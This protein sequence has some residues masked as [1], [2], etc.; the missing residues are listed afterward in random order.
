MKINILKEKLKKG[1][2]IVEKISQKS[3]KLPILQ[4]I[5]FKSEKDL[6]K[7][8]TTNLESSISWQSLADI[9][10]EGSICIPT[11]ILSSFV[12]SLPEEKIS[13][14]TDKKNNL[15]V[16]CGNYNTKIKIKL[17]KKRRVSTE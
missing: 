8:S 6:L 4:N 7:L 1:L 3:L 15:K 13:I 14:E 11:K 9:K 16:K 10:K 12:N 2:N 17:I 5:L